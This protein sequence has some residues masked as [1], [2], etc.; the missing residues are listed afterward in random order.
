MED[1]KEIAKFMGAEEDF[2]GE[3][4]LFSVPSLNALF[5][6]VE[7]DDAEAKHYYKPSEMEFHD[8]YNWLMSAVEAIEATGAKVTIGRMFC[9]ITYQHPLY[10][11]NSFETNMVSGVKINSIHAAVVEFAKWHNSKKS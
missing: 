5:E 4:D 2:R 8:S 7:A 6:D 1:N 11:D 10:K 9:N 3:F